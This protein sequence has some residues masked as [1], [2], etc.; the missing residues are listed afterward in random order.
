MKQLLSGFLLLLLSAAA[1]SQSGTDRLL[2]E[3]NKAIETSP[4]YDEEK[5]KNIDLLKRSFIERKND[6]LPAL[7]NIYLQLYEEYKV[8]KY[9]SAFSYARQLQATAIQLGDPTRIVYAR[10]KLG[11][12]LLS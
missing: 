8:Y 10:L 3:L 2:N 6:D 1:Q 11:F 9:D 4:K 12:S 7:F 5:Q